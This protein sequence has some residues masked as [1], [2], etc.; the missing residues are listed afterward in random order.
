[1][2]FAEIVDRAVKAHGVMFPESEVYA[3]HIRDVDANSTHYVVDLD[4][5]H[6]SQWMTY[7]IEKK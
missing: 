3:C 5:T 1:M 4:A 2:S 6:F 7:C